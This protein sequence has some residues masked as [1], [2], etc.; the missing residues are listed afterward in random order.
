MAPASVS[1]TESCCAAAFLLHVAADGA[2]VTRQNGGQSCCSAGLL[3]SAAFLPLHL[4][5]SV[6][7]GCPSSAPDPPRTALVPIEAGD[8][9][10]VTNA[11]VPAAPIPLP[12]RGHE[13][14][15][16]VGSDSWC[17]PSAESAPTRH[18]ACGTR[19][20]AGTAPRVPAH[21]SACLGPPLPKRK[22]FGATFIGGCATGGAGADGA[23][24]LHTAE[25]A[26][27]RTTRCFPGTAEDGSKF[28]RK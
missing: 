6:S 2:I 22:P 11:D 27:S 20:A 23:G 25:L 28:S 18:V 26:V 15:G 10:G 1:Q 9:S 16:G 8:V 5:H 3:F 17:V 7:P 14:L 13:G 4:P 12:R 19:G 24:H 21:H